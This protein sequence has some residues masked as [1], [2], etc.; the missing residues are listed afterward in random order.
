MRTLHGRP[1]ID[2]MEL[3]PK[4]VEYSPERGG[5]DFAVTERRKDRLDLI[6]LAPFAELPVLTNGQGGILMTMHRMSQGGA[7]RVAVLLANGFHARG[8][9]VDFLLLRSGGEGE[10]ALSHLLDPG[11]RLHTAGPPM[12]SRHL[13]LA[14]GIAAIRAVASAARPSLVL[15]SS[16]N[17][18]LVTGLACR[19]LRRKG[20]GVAMKLTNPV[21]R[22][23]DK[24]AA[25]KFY[26]KT[27]YR[28]IFNQ[29]DRILTLT[30]AETSDLAAMFPDAADRLTTVPN[31]YLSDGLLAT[32][33]PRGEQN[34]ERKGNGPRLLTLA[35]MMPQ[36]RL[37]VMLHAFAKLRRPDARLTI[38]GDGPQRLRLEELA[39][40]LG[41]AERVE[42]PGF[43]EDVIPALSNADIFLLSSDYEG[44]PAAVIEA[45]ACN[46]PVVTTDC[47]PGAREMLD[48][49]PFCAVTPIGDAAELAR[50]IEKIL[51]LGAPSGLR[52]IAADYGIDASIAAHVRTL[53]PLMG[54]R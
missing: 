35:R 37:D 7:D 40:T 31:A 44:L 33:L 28:F 22:P 26:R 50:A 54:P 23:R 11:V 6:N 19:P 15:A 16:S 10:E 4:P 5:I 27:L 32:E 52:E 3:A 41:I 47:F 38:L 34:C 36:K 25:Q 42:M 30:R 53:A 8:I 24:F 21:I 2:P 43:V 17:M 14:R 20:I 46:V 45:L 18:G 1:I 49:S 29:H 51:G 13:E 9:P 39:R 48:G 12:G